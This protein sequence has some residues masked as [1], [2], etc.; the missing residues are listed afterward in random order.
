MNCWAV[1]GI[2]RTSDTAI[3]KKAYKQQ[4][5]VHHPEDD[6]G[7][8]QKVRAAYTAAMND[9]KLL[10]KHEE[11]KTVVESGEQVE[12]YTQAKDP[13]DEDVRSYQRLFKIEDV[14]LREVDAEEEGDDENE[15][16]ITVTRH[17]LAEQV[18]VKKHVENDFIKRMEQLF[19]D[20]VNRN[21]PESWK[22]LLSDDVL[23]DIHSKS[24]IDER[25]LRLLLEKYIYLNDHIF[26]I[27]E[28]HM[29]LFEKIDRNMDEY[30]ARF[31]DIYAL[32][33][34]KVAVPHSLKQAKTSPEQILKRSDISWWKYCFGNPI[35]WIIMILLGYHFVIPLYLLVILVRCVLFV[36]RRNWK[37][38]MWEYTFTYTNQWG[39]HSDFKY[40][41]II[42]IELLKKKVI[43][44][45]KSEQIHIKARTTDNLVSLLNRMSRYGRQEG[46]M[47]IVQ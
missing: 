2:N 38:S 44:H 43:I 22:D 29:G 26:K 1:L 24:R 32:A 13:E 20:E 16:L 39:K 35:G 34:Q 10:A 36:L 45:L 31:I 42:K 8:Y 46:N 4:L 28:S 25:M 23:W 17:F 7:G 5:L 9:A 30:P 3:I 27:I 14:A 15:K 21:N 18:Q 12:V 47:I 37:I 41:D 6:P 40:I 19:N 33:T 11:A